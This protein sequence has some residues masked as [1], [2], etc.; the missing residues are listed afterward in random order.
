MTDITEF[1]AFGWRDMLGTKEEFNRLNKNKM[2]H[3]SIDENVDNLVDNLSE[4]DLEILQEYH[5]SNCAEGVLGDDL[6]DHFDNWL[7]CLTLAEVNAILKKKDEVDLDVINNK[8]P[9]IC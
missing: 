9:N 7:S 6:P 2:S 5:C 3:P 1:M 8:N 4:L